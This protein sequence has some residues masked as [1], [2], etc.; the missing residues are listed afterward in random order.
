[1]KLLFENWRN[2]QKEVVL[3]QD[4]NLDLLRRTVI[5]RRGPSGARLG[6]GMTGAMASG[7]TEIAKMVSNKRFMT[8]AAKQAALMLVGMYDFTGITGYPGLKQAYGD[9]SRTQNASNAGL[10]LLAVLGSLPMIGGW[11][12]MGAKGA[13]ST[14]KVLNMTN[15]AKRIVKRFGKSKKARCRLREQQLDESRFEFCPISGQILDKAFEPLERAAAK[16][17]PA[18]K[19]QKMAWAGAKIKGLNPAF[20]P[21]TGKP[22]GVFVDQRGNAYVMVVT[23]EGPVTF[24]YSSG[25]SMLVVNKAEMLW[26]RQGYGILSRAKGRR[27]IIL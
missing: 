6:T 25:T 16:A 24:M 10:F 27:M 21:K 5:P 11:S 17:G 8:K 23:E 19:T 22:Y 20:S 4:R 9:F 14:R 13:K 15:R 26:E 18:R 3:E 1:M 7:A 12:R 2:Y